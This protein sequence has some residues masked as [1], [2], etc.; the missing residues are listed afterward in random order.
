MTRFTT[1]EELEAFLNKIHE[2]YGGLYAEALWD[3]GRNV[4]SSAELANATVEVLRLAGVA[5]GL[6]AQ[7]IITQAKGEGGGVECI[8]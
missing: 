3:G 1:K 2:T 6:H 7:N 5:Y 8:L 4:T